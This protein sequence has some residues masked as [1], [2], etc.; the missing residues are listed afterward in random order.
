HV[1]VSSKKPYW[2]FGGLQDNGSWGGPSVGLH[3]SGPINEDWISVGGGDG[4]V[5]RVDA[6]D[7][8]VVYAESQNG[9]ITRYN[10]RTGERGSACPGRAGWRRSRRR[11]SPTAGRTSP[12]T[13]TGRTTTSRMFI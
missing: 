6:N 2:V 12:S 11:G 1:A 10:T 13:A 5:C 9:A 4:F 8:D 3:G 7:P